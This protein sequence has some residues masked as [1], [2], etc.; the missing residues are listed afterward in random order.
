MRSLIS[1]CILLVA[2][3]AYAEPVVLAVDGKDIYVDVGAKD[4]VGTGSVLE[5]LHE[6]TA[7]DPKTGATLHDR[8]ALGTITVAKSGKTV[9][10]AHADED[11]AKRVLAGDHVR[12]VSDKRSFVDPWE[13]QVAA[14]KGQPAPLPASSPN[15][16]TPAAVSGMSPAEH[17]NAARDA[18]QETLGQPI[19]Q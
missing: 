11:L 8:F 16:P 1:I 4:G 15:V 13:E 12:L 17:A 7:R 18:W 3:H 5:L 6:I 2:T 19:D 10:I 9:S 14:S